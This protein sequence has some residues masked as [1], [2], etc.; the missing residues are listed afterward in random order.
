MGIIRTQYVDRIVFNN[1]TDTADDP[2]LIYL[3]VRD[4][5]QMFV[6]RTTSNDPL[7]VGYLMACPVDVGPFN[8]TPMLVDI[9]KKVDPL[10]P[11]NQA[12]INH[13][14]DLF[15]QPDYN[16]VNTDDCLSHHDGSAGKVQ[17]TAHGETKGDRNRNGTLNSLNWTLVENR[18]ASVYYDTLVLC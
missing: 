11:Q 6:I 9:W 7:A 1:S 8:Y 14:Y 12:C 15:L 18:S 2:A 13:L 3:I 17:S 4:F 5:D 16:I 10:C